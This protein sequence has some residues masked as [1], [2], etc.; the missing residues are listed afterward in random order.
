MGE[1]H[2]GWKVVITR[3]GYH[4]W[5]TDK[6]W[7]REKEQY[8]S[9]TNKYYML[10]VKVSSLTP[11]LPPR[12]NEPSIH[13]KNQ[14]IDSIVVCRLLN[15]RSKPNSYRA[16]GI[17]VALFWCLGLHL[18]SLHYSYFFVFFA[19]LL[20]PFS[21]ESHLSGVCSWSV[22]TLRDEPSIVCPSPKSGTQKYS[23][24]RDVNLTEHVALGMWGALPWQ[25]LLA[26]GIYSSTWPSSIHHSAEARKD[27]LL[28]ERLPTL[29]GPYN[30]SCCCSM[31]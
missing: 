14:Y 4:S 8:K 18:F 31:R 29:K 23:P 1:R 10:M 26:C 17:V 12:W 22:V 16:S 28:E 11:F 20:Y 9:W 3:K 2:V 25:V 6:S 24:H 19:W 30:L 7:Q 21:F 13:K 27:L 5:G 15:Y